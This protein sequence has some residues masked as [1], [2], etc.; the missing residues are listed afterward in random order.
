MLNNYKSNESFGSIQ[1]LTSS[2]EIT[3]EKGQYAKI[4]VWVKTANI[5]QHTNYGQVIGANIRIQNSFAGNS[6]QDFGVYNILDT[7][8]TQ[9][10]FYVKA[11]DVYDTKF[12]VVLGLGYDDYKAEGTVYFDDVQ[13]E[14]LDGILEEELDVTDYN[15][16]YKAE[17]NDLKI[18]AETAKTQIP[19][20]D[21]TIDFADIDSYTKDN[22]TSFNTV[23][24]INTPYANINEG[25][26]I[27]LDTPSSYTLKLDNNGNNFSVDKQLFHIIKI[28]LL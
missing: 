24:E 14:L 16:S 12:T 17:T 7:E 4:S 18:P 9:Y 5:N 28:W 10:S 2:T 21:M 26:I 23:S 19:L 3:L 8:W 20:Y 11:D 6:Q 25:T 1:K 13:V 27:N 15:I 22:V